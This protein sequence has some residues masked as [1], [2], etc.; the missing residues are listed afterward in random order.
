M[1]EVEDHPAETSSA[2]CML[3]IL[4]SN[5]STI[6]PAELEEVSASRLDFG[7]Q[8]RGD[9]VEGMVTL[10]TCESHK[11]CQ[12]ARAKEKY[13]PKPTAMMVKEV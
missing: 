13:L 5:S 9:E 4:L 2:F 12:P 6:L 3:N 11:P 1:G 8:D 10:N 7:R